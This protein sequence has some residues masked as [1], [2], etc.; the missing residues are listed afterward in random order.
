[1]PKPDLF[2]R[3]DL[4]RAA[5]DL[6]VRLGVDPGHDPLEVSLTQTGRMKPSLQSRTWMRFTALQSIST[7]VCQFDWRA[8]AGPFGLISG[9]DA[10][11]NGEGRFDITALGFIPLARAKHTVALVR[12]ELMRYLAEL[13][14]APDAIV[15]NRHLRWREIDP[16]NL[17]V[18]AG[19]D[20]ATSEVVL[21]L[22]SDGRIASAFAPDR[23]R[24]ASPP[25][26]PTPW[27][28]RFSE[29]RLHNKRWI[30]FSGDVG[31]EIKGV[32]EVYWE[33]R[34]VGWETDQRE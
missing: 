17:S 2:S 3:I 11:S 32:R 25:L 28:G 18:S 15:H 20:E 23:P 12:G 19:S 34:L 27:R 30:P 6:A 8:K 5:Y 33:T 13:A 24:S 16:D 26:L 7:R 9:R 21:T 14:W 31:W 29:Y 4:P 10:L 1:M 22:D